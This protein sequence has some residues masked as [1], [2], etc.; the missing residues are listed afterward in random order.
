ML[1]R[2]VLESLGVLHG[3]LKGTFL[4]GL[5]L[6]KWMYY[7]LYE[8]SRPSGL[9]PVEVE[10]ASLLVDARDLGVASFLITT[11]T[12]E[13]FEL[14]L[15]R[16]LLRPGACVVDVGANFG[17]YSVLVAQA[18]GAR[19]RVYCFEPA[20]DNFEILR[21]NIHRNG[22]AD[23]VTA[24]A[25][26]LSNET[27]EGWLFLHPRNQGDHRIVA[28]PSERRATV[29]VAV[30][31]LDDVLPRGTPVDLIKMDVQGAEMLALQGMQRVLDEN[32]DL[33]LVME[34]WPR[35]IRRSGCEPLEFAEFVRIH[36]FATY[37][38]HERT[39]RLA[40]MGSVDLQRCC[41]RA[42]PANLVLVR[43]S[44]EQIL[45]RLSH[46]HSFRPPRE[47]IEV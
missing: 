1:K 6:A 43:G 12:Y 45:E 22:L 24:Y 21:R 9:H 32:R 14:S 25:T 23:R 38:I 46:G 44:S 26:A 13:P 27:R 47:H 10:G 7:R 19:G 11:G 31:R 28:G 30:S 3:T 33:A 18:V 15:I 42:E 29:R 36:Q 2:T 40:K 37:R 16:R 4:A 20:P 34:F 5:P 17:Y 41:R 39:R 35:A 8:W